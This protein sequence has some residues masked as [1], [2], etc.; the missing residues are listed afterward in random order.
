[1]SA[2]HNV[3]AILFD[4]DGTLCPDT[5]DFLLH[6]M[7]IDVK[8]FWKEITTMVQSGWD[9]QLAYI[10]K[11]VELNQM[12]NL[13]ITNSKLREIGSEI[14]FYLGIPD[15]FKELTDFI[16]QTKDFTETGIV[17][18]YY[19]ISSGIEEIIRGS[20]IAQYVNDIFG[21]RF[22]NDPQTWLIKCPKAVISFTDKTRYVWAI[23]KGISGDELRRAPYS[24]NDV[25]K[26]EDRPV[27]FSNM[28]YV[29]DGPSDIPCF[30]M[31][32]RNEGIGIGVYS[33]SA[34]KKGYE[35]ARGDRTTLGPFLADY[36]KGTDLRRALENA[37]NDISYHIV[38]KNK[39]KRR[40]APSF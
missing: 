8:E 3:I 20:K 32:K 14:E 28:I 17:L 4:C 26:E 31:I 27:P 30:S 6:K 2:V 21:S 13:G 19:V 40:Q 10:T 35:L 34:A 37:I 38:L 9:P 1:M 15:A 22:E 23:H 16:S 39:E 7:G 5:T 18:R 24:V 29:G 25:V 11:V 12:K 33:S 36:R